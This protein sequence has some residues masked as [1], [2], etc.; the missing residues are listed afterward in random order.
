[1][2]LATFAISE[3]ILK[4][5]GFDDSD[6]TDVLSV[7]K[8]L[9]ACCDCEVLYNVALN[10]RLKTRYWQSKATVREVGAVEPPHHSGR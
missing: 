6:V 1:M 9:G 4:S 10:N 5:L 8:S 7:L 2:S 3:S